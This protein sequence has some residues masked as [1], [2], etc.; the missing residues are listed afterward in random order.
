MGIRAS[1]AMGGVHVVRLMH[2]VLATH[3]YENIYS[4]CNFKSPS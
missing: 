1:I 4:A 3:M 2:W